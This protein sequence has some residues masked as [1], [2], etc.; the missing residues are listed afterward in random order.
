MKNT[1]T[2]HLT[3]AAV[4]TALVFAVT[5]FIQ[6]PIPL[7]YFNVGNAII[8]L[9]CLLI[10]APYGIYA[11]SLGSAFADLTSYP[12]YT[13][14]TLIIKAL[15]P[16]VFYLII[17]REFSAKRSITAFAI[18]TLIPLFG[19]TF[20][21]ALLYGGLLAGLAQFPGLLLEYIANVAIFT[22]LIPIFARIRKVIHL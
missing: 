18:A 14:P 21:G 8:L 7:G 16:S 22:A 4:L 11:G 6:I 3:A 2:K 5:R 10:P 19:Y 1:S 15:M 20:T 9:G 13:I 17:R 12:A